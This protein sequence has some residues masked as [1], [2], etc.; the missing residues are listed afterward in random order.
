MKEDNIILADT[1]K[2]EAGASTSI[3]TVTFSEFRNFD[4]NCSRA[5]KR[6]FDCSNRGCDITVEKTGGGIVLKLNAGSYQLIK[7]AAKEFYT[8]ESQP[9]ACTITPVFDKKGHQLETKYRLSKGRNSLYTLNLYHTRCSALINGKCEQHFIETDFPQIMHIVQEKLN[10]RN[11][12]LGEF[13]ANVKSSLLNLRDISEASVSHSD[14]VII[15]EMADTSSTSENESTILSESAFHILSTSSGNTCSTPRKLCNSPD[16]LNDLNSKIEKIQT[17]L[18]EHIIKTEQQMSSLRDEIYSVK[19]NTNLH[20]RRLQEEIDAIH[21]ATEAV[22]RLVS[23][24]TQALKG[25]IQTLSDQVRASFDNKPSTSASGHTTRTDGKTPDPHITATQ[26]SKADEPDRSGRR[27]VQTLSSGNQ[28]EYFD[29]APVY[30]IGD[31][32]LKGIQTRGLHNDVDVNTL[33]GKKTIDVCYRLM[34]QDLST[35]NTVV[36]Y[37]GGNDVASGI[38]VNQMQRELINMLNT[39]EN[40]KRKVYLCTLCPRIDADVR[41]VNNMIR[42]VCSDS[43]AELLDVHR[44]FVYED[45]KPRTYLYHADGIH[46]NTKGSSV[47]VRTLNNTV[48]IVRHTSHQPRRADG[49]DRPHHWPRQTGPRRQQWRNQRQ[50][51]CNNC[52]LR[53]HSTSD[54]RRLLRNR[55]EH[56]RVHNVDDAARN[57]HTTR[58]HRN[59]QFAANTDPA[60]YYRD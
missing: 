40:S 42:K 54:C 57:W 3:T 15:T 23:D 53:N 20:H 37:V 7:S 51:P 35:C 55:S 12:T 30:I 47:L 6:L 4:M 10:D 58:Y 18:Q 1:G 8:G 9:L 50:P 14:P 25:R 32:I 19:T 36:V 24:S 46:L 43:T 22:E 48:S 17:T 41:P 44:S 49:Y 16:L 38:S 31:S 56:S 29:I 13:N 2:N 21:R 11:T 45:G 60:S 39:N 5:E 52:G 33:P 28:I 26:V 27:H 59:R 34:H